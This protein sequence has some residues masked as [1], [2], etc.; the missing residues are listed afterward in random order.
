MQRNIHRNVSHRLSKNN[1]LNI[2]SV[3]LGIQCLKRYTNINTKHST[4]DD[5]ALAEIFLFILSYFK[6]K[7][8]S[9]LVY[10]IL[11]FTIK[12]YSINIRIF[13]IIED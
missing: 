12:I 6:W 4:D 10:S 1:I 5:S 3:F 13:Q 8:D 2:E 9:F 7:R 11:L